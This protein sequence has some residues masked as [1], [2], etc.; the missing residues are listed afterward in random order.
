[1][2]L[3]HS[4]PGWIETKLC[5]IHQQWKHGALSGNPRCFIEESVGKAS[6]ATQVHPSDTAK[7]LPL[8]TGHRKQ[9]ESIGSK[10]F[11]EQYFGG[12]DEMI[13]AAEGYR[14]AFVKTL[15]LPVRSVSPN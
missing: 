15:M 14:E 12:Y 7:L 4:H 13:W 6:H 2:N 9:F 1:M 11:G 5:A 10:R 8:C 3:V